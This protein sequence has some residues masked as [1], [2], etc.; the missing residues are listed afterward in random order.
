MHMM[1]GAI[2]AWVLKKIIGYFRTPQKTKFA[3]SSLPSRASS[4]SPI[5]TGDRLRPSPSR[6]R[7]PE[8]RQTPFPSAL[9]RSRPPFSDSDSLIF[10]LA[11]SGSI[12]L[13]SVLLYQLITRRRSAEV[14]YAP[15]R[16]IVS[17]PRPLLSICLHNCSRQDSSFRHAV[18]Y[19]QR[20]PANTPY[21]D[22]LPSSQSTP[23]L[24]HRQPSPTRRNPNDRVR[25]SKIE[26]IKYFY[27]DEIIGFE[28]G[29]PA[30]T[31]RRSLSVS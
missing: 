27:K 25:L 13:G 3:P 16:P 11:G 18:H 12:L 23:S 4:P 5:K 19:E 6:S 14:K 8:R 24:S 10:T 29:P 22:R 26:T 17:F 20:A 28:N 21:L 2:C 1:L 15:N 7:L 9:Q 31:R 30:R